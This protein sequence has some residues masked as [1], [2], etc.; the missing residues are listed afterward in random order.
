M[1]KTKDKIINKSIELFNEFGFS[2]ISLFRI[3]DEL[4]VS[5]GNLT[6]HYNKKDDLMAAVYKRFQDE[7]AQITPPDYYNNQLEEMDQQLAQF[8]MLQ[9]RFTFFYLDLLEIERAFPAIAE[10]HYQHIQKQIERLREVLQYNK[11]T[12]LLK[13]YQNQEIYHRIAHHIWMM[14]VYWLAQSK[15]RGTETSIDDLRESFWVLLFPHLTVQGA[16]ELNKFYD[17]S[18]FK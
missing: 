11:S 4:G 17:M 15:I 18:K 1:S 14:T 16:G 3:A 10:K 7:L 8:F 6:Y 2:N 9:E 12:G 13:Q 5:P